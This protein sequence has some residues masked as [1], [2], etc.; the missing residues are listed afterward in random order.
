MWAFIG[1]FKL[2]QAVSANSTQTST[3][4]GFR[5][6]RSS[7]RMRRASFL[8]TS[9]L[10][11]ASPLTASLRTVWRARDFFCCSFWY[12]LTAAASSGL[13]RAATFFIPLASRAFSAAAIALTSTDTTS[14]PLCGATSVSSDMVSLLPKMKTAPNIGAAIVQTS[15]LV[16]L[17]LI[18]LVRDGVVSEQ[19]SQLV[20]FF[21][22]EDDVFATLHVQAARC[23]R[24]VFGP[25]LRHPADQFRDNGVGDFFEILFCLFVNAAGF[26]HFGESIKSVFRSLKVE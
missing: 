15:L 6:R 1:I 11:C 8:E 23:R 2:R 7:T 24:N 13:R 5:I 16:L 18:G 10:L 17:N 25:L 21:L 3:I 26:I 22:R 20:Q 9:S 19:P 4:L 14:V 12:F